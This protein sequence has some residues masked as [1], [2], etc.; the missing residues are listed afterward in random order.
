MQDGER[1]RV[2]VT[3]LGMITPLGSTVE[4]TWD[5]IIAGR[6]GIGPITRFD[7]TGLETTIAGEVRD[8][9]PKAYV[10]PRKSLKVMSREIQFGFA[11][12]EMALGEAGFAPEVVA[13]ERIGVVFGADPIYSDL[14]EMEAVYRR[15]IV[16][17]KFVYE[18]W[19][20]AP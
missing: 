2:V 10:R 1:R 18:R 7:A 8:F 11:A 15:S 20:R 16:E 17:G 14:S 13:P 19:R 4:K 6:S 3:G 9:D 5:G 12:A